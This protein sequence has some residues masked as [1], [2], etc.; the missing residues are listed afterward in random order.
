MDLKLLVTF[1]LWGDLGKGG[2][3]EG[4][5]ADINAEAGC[6]VSRGSFAG[7]RQ[8]GFVILHKSSAFFLID[9]VQAFGEEVSKSVGG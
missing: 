1:D 5:G 6:Q 9:R 4:F 2:S 8:E 3:P 7:A